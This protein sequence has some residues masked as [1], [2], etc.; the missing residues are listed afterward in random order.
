MRAQESGLHEWAVN[1][2]H[3][4]AW[5]MAVVVV[6]SGGGDANPQADEAKRLIVRLL[7]YDSIGEEAV[8]CQRMRSDAG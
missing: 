1:L 6:I 4:R 8:W 3:T 7:L 5:C 2:P